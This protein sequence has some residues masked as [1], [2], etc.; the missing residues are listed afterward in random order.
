MLPVLL[1]R[2]QVNSA[3]CRSPGVESGRQAEGREDPGTLEH[4]IAADARGG[5]GEDLERVRLVAAAG[6]QVR[7]ET[8]LAVG[9]DRL[10][11]PVRSAHPEDPFHEQAVVTA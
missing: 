3:S 1:A 9:R 4:R 5:D 11:A 2:W 7:G 6:A 8:G 10:Q